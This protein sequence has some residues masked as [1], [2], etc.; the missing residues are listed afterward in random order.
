MDSS[1]SHHKSETNLLRE[2]AQISNDTDEIGKFLLDGGFDV[3]DLPIH[4]ALHDFERGHLQ[5]LGTMKQLG[6]SL[7]VTLSQRVGIRSEGTHLLSDSSSW[8]IDNPSERR[9]EGRIVHQL[10]VCQH[11]LD[12]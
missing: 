3:R 4:D 2:S 10:E 1:L 6:N 7:I 9:H 8:N 5:L 11:V 12:L